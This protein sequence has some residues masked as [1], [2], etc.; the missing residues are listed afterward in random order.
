MTGNNHEQARRLIAL[1]N[2]LPESQRSWLRAHL[3]QCAGCRDY[4]EA[5]SR[6]VAGLRSLPMAADSRLVRATQMRV[7]FHAHRLRETR[8]R[9]WMVGVACLGVGL[10]AAVTAPLLW[11]LFAWMGER[12]G[13]SHTVWQTAYAA[14]WIAPAL[15]VSVL[16]LARGIHLSDSEEQSREP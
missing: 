7:R 12:A 1:G 5:S 14:F 9:M 13:V 10:S 16:L 2:A 8:A 15:V 3:E 6:V 11:R 4:A